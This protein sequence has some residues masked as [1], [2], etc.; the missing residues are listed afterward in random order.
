MSHRFEFSSF[1][2]R[3]ILA[4]RKNR[5]FLEQGQFAYKS[6]QLEH[7]TFVPC[8]HIQPIGEMYVVLRANEGAKVVDHWIKESFKQMT[9]S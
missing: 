5:V 9:F 4:A 3:K 8:D 7:I 6:E 1:V 2:R